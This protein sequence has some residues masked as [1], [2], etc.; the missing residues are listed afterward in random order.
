VLAEE[1]VIDDLNWLK[2]NSHPWVT[3]EQKWKKTALYRTRAL[4]SGSKK[5]EDFKLYSDP[6]AASLV[7]AFSNLNFFP[8]CF[9]IYGHPM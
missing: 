7:T 6:K 1:L 9:V 2:Y 5:L 4:Q 3:V 8:N